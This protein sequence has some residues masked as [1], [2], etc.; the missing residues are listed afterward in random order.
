[1]KRRSA[2]KLIHALVLS[3]AL[4]AASCLTDPAEAA[5]GAGGILPANARAFGKSLPEWFSAYFQWYAG[6][7]ADPAQSMVGGVQLVPMPA[8]DWI[9]GSGTP[10]DPALLRGQLELTLPAGTP[11]VLPAYAWQGERYQGYPNIP[12][13]PP[14]PDAAVL[15]GVHPALTIDGKTVLTDA[16]KAAYYLAPVFYEQVV[17]Y[18]MPTSYGSVGMVFVQGGAVVGNPLP[19]GRHVI[20]LYEPFSLSAGVYPTYPDGF[21]YIYD[22][23]WIIN[24]V[25]AQH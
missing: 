13:D 2:T 8:G 6:T 12:D 17:T 20:H 3:L 24:V 5:A 19:V 25:P 10:D 15:A 7:G 21:G 9:S 22:N 18:P 23:T 4:S 1:M 16:N 11:F 14:V